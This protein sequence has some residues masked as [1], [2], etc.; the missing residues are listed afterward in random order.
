M[1]LY[2]TLHRGT[3]VILLF[4]KRRNDTQPAV[5]RRA[6]VMQAPNHLYARQSERVTFLAT[7]LLNLLNVVPA[8]S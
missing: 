5:R 4:L 3:R 1:V 2:T 7:V 8:D 6:Q